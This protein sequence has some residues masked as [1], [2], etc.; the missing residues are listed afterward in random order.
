[1]LA[2]ISNLRLGF[3]HTLTRHN[4]LGDILAQSCVGDK[5]LQRCAVYGLGSAKVLD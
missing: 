2:T 4:T 5:H 3:A 1:M